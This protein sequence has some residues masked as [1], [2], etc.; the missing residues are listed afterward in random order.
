MIR[1]DPLTPSHGTLL[2][3]IA[4]L[5]REEALRHDPRWD[6]LTEATL[7]DEERESLRRR[8]V[9]SEDGEALWSA[10]D[11]LSCA[12]M[13]RISAR[14]TSSLRAARPRRSY[15]RAL[16]SA[17]AVLS[18]AAVALGVCVGL[19]RSPPSSVS[20]LPATSPGAR[21]AITDLPRY[22]VEVRGGDVARAV[23]GP[24]P[25]ASA[26]SAGPA[27]PDLAPVVLH[28]GATLE[29]TLR[30][31]TAVH[32]PVT[33]TACLVREGRVTPW[34]A[35][36]ER[37]EQGAFHAQGS[38]ESLFPAEVTGDV[39]LLFMV[40]AADATMDCAAVVES[41]EA[42]ARSIHLQ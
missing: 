10:F 36:W 26:Q 9:E 7:P 14:V 19:Q 30:P 35:A 17:A 38:R 15:G 24:E 22:R 21:L 2:R 8:A 28:R 41:S 37:S 34:T 5:E 12:A 4:H 42:F 32:G 29:I 20:E 39:T 25:A 6:R 18:V 40:L 11:P 23:R 31:E 3:A 16:L 27:T 33:L 1:H 13:D